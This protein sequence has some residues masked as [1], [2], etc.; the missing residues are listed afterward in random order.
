MTKSCANLKIDK[1][2]H[3]AKGAETACK[4]HY[5]RFCY[6]NKVVKETR[7]DIKQS[8]NWTVE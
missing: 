3:S 1:R 7:K 8:L 6:W 5:I 2:N 4:I